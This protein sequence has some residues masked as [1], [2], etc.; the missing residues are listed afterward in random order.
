MFSSYG[1]YIL[2]TNQ[3]TLLTK[4]AESSSDCPSNKTAKRTIIQ[5]GR[6]S[7]QRYMVQ[8]TSLENPVIEKT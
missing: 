5:N 4:S 6:Y 8:V 2:H 1:A 7:H 3:S